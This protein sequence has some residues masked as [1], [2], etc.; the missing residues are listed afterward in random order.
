MIL[1]NGVADAAL[2]V[3]DRGLAYGDGVFRTFPYRDGAPVLWR[4]QYE[5]LAR[6]CRALG[7]VT[8]GAD[9]L[10]R[11]L[12]HITARDCVVKVVVT[13][14]ESAR[15][16]AP[17]R[18]AQPVRIVMTSEL[19]A[20]PAERETAGIDVRVCRLKLSHQPRLA[21]IKHLNRLENVLAR[22]EWDDPAIAE[23][24]LCDAEGHLICGTMS[25]V[26]LV[27][28]GRLF[29]PQLYQCGVKGVMRDL[30]ID[31]AEA[32]RVPVNVDVLTIDQLREA[33]AAFVVN[34]LIGLWPIASV[35]G[36]ALRS[37]PLPAQ[38]QQWIRD[39]QGT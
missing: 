9:V 8:P 35:D 39:A 10:E 11:D 22:A 36:Q 34:S 6:D 37:S 15:G 12:R 20:Y 27:Q 1:V 2:S 7:I 23:G 31:V 29:T 32:H 26:F 3:R 30:V 24:L 28:L 33:D 38:L 21:G 13:R 4:R 19:P 5:K 18:D 14:G 16:Y 17:S 25:N